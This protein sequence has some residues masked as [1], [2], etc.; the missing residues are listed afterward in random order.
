MLSINLYNIAI[1]NIPSV[2]YRCSVSEICICEA[3]TLLKMP[4]W[5]K[6]LERYKN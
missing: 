3:V 1:L 2:D 6:K 4:I 5:T